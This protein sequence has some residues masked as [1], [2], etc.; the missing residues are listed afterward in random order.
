[1]TDGDTRRWVEKPGWCMCN[2][3]VGQ[4]HLAEQIHGVDVYWCDMCWYRLVLEW[5]RK[6]R[7]GRTARTMGGTA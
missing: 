1:M 4:I 5:K 3:P 2:D 6:T 7:S